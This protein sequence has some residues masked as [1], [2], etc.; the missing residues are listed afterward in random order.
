VDPNRLFYLNVFR[1]FA[2]QVDQEMTMTVTQSRAR[3]VARKAAS[4]WQYR[5]RNEKIQ[6]T[7][8]DL[9]DAI[10][11]ELER[12]KMFATQ[13]MLSLVEHAK[14]LA[15]NQFWLT[16][17]PPTNADLIR[18]IGRRLI[19]AEEVIYFECVPTTISGMGDWYVERV[20]GNHHEV[21]RREKVVTFHG[22]HA[23]QHAADWVAKHLP[24]DPAPQ[25]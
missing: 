16:G 8:G 2:E 19:E 17:S 11:D 5:E 24:I 23:K 15:K 22:A 25:P 14:A 7:A 6:Y 1:A 18:A 9:P 13:D 3:D 4:A 10:V 21:T 12:Q 20:I